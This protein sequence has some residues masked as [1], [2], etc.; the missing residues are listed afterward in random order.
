[1]G[2]LGTLILFFGWFGFNPGS[3][4]G[5]TTGLHNLA[6]LAAVNTLLAGAA[7]GASSMF[8][9]WWFGPSKKPDPAMSVN[10]VLGGL[11]AITAPCAFVD[12]WAAVAIGLVV[13]VIVPVASAALEKFHVDDP[14]G[15]TPVHFFGG[16]WG[17]LSVG[18]FANGNPDSAGWNGITA[19]VVGLLYGGHTQIVA[20]LLEMITIGVGVTASGYAFF[21]VL[22]AFGLLRSKAED[23]LAG[24][25]IPEMGTP[26]YTTDDLVLHG[27]RKGGRMRGSVSPVL[28]PSLSIEERTMP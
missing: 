11:V 3:A 17:V 16:L 7:G 10:G 6:S 27:G 22:G 12:T 25:D 21:K 1:M 24:L 9:M 23:E 13:G 18:I 2:V 8:Y 14:V 4:L 26:G 20:Q 28:S 19:P 15:A 5:F